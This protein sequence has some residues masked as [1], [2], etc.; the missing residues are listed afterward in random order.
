MMGLIPTAMMAAIGQREAD[1][2][3]RI[4]LEEIQYDGK[5]VEPA[6]DVRGA[7]HEAAGGDGPLRLVP[8]APTGV[9]MVVSEDDCNVS[10]VD[11][12]TS[13]PRVT[14]TLLVGDEPRDIVFAGTGGT[15]R[16]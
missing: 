14:R 7:H 8:F 1:V 2:D 4:G 10:V 5:H 11:V 9:L 13:P 3:V 15:A 6:E 16:S 12:A